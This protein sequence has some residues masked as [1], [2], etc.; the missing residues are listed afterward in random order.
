MASFFPP[1]YLLPTHLSPEARQELEDQIPTLTHDITKAKLILGKVATKQRAKFELRSRKLWTEEVIQGIHVT[2]LS[3]GAGRRPELSP[4]LRQRVNIENGEGELLGSST[5]TESEATLEA[6]SEITKAGSDPSRGIA[7]SH[8]SMSPPPPA[9]PPAVVSSPIC[10]MSQTPA[11]P[12]T[13]PS[14]ENIWGDT[15]QVV[16]LPW[17]HECL[18]VGCL[19]PFGDNL[20]YEGRL[21]QSV[22]SAKQIIAKVRKAYVSNIDRMLSNFQ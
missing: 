11:K 6:A 16:K 19:V 1:I 22:I 18:A 20:I 21:A 4:T 3:A 7:R 5:E 15:V 10:S 9:T 13:L 12:L 14:E 17:F 8:Q 2:G